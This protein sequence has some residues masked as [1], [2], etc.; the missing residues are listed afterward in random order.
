MR[1]S[2]RSPFF[3][4][5]INHRLGGVPQYLDKIKSGKYFIKNYL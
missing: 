2:L 3:Q 1:Y 4:S 5:Q